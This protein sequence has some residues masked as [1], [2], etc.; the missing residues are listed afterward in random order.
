M[1]DASLFGGAGRAA[2][3]LLRKR[4]LAFP[5]K[6]QI[7]TTAACNANCVM[8]PHYSIKRDRGAMDQGLFRRIVDECASAPEGVDELYP[9]LNGEL[10]L[11]PGWENYLA[12]AREKLRRTKISLFTNGSL[13][14][15]ANA[16]SLLEIGPD[17]VNV[18]FDGTDKATY[19]AVRR[20]LR[21]EEVEENIRSLVSRRAA[22]RLARPRI[23]LSIVEMERTAP[24]IPD[25]VKRWSGVVDAVTVEPFNTWT[26][27]VGDLAVPGRPAR[28]RVP[29]PR[30]WYNLTVL[31]SGKAALCCL[32]Y[33]GKVPLGDLNSMSVREVWR[34]AAARELRAAHERG[35]YAGLTLCE[36]CDYGK[37]Q[38]ETPFWWV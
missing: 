7:E 27:A 25:F 15:G 35:L 12:Y 5:R 11:T 6:V 14:N 38:A 3:R 16:A 30:L 17:H 4:L 26:G 28:P 33:E 34:G 2:A 13:L 36:N 8:C 1:T 31:N 18:S 32:D 10:F 24:G 19:E 21:F 9:F 37:Y 23:T 29:C 22:L 20:N